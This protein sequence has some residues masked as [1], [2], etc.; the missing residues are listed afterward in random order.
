[1]YRNA[2]DW[3]V[4]DVTN[5]DGQHVT[6]YAANGYHPPGGE[7]KRV[8]I[9]AE[10]LINP[11]VLFLDEVSVGAGGSGGGSVSVSAGWSVWAGVAV[12]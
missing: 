6:S 5:F 8:S 2:E 7:R 4:R 1:V 3:G 9:G 11:S 10:L 12:K